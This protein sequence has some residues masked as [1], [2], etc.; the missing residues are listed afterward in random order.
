LFGLA[1]VLVATIP[2]AASVAL[3]WTPPGRLTFGVLCAA[4]IAAVTC[5]TIGQIHFGVEFGS[6]SAADDITKAELGLLTQPTTR[7]VS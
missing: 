2:I 4:V 7:P 5:F 1:I 6:S 3:G